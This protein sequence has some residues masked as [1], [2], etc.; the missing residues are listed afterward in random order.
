[1]EEEEIDFG[2]VTIGS[3]MKHP[4]SLFNNGSIQATVFID[5]ERYPE[6]TIGLAPA[7]D[8]QQTDLES[9]FVPV[10]DTRL[11]SA[12]TQAPST[13]ATGKRGSSSRS[14]R[15]GKD[16]ETSDEVPQARKFRLLVEPG[17]G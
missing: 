5:L 8:G 2:G 10:M 17:K 14:K 9:V 4:I 16:N 3:N 1:M 7:G 15:K 11:N 12:S 6:F 13:A